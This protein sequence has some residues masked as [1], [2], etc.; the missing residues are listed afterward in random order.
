[1]P[2]PALLQS[3]LCHHAV[4]RLYCYLELLAVSGYSSEGPEELRVLN[5]VPRYR[6]S[7]PSSGKGRENAGSE[8]LLL[9]EGL[10]LC[11]MPVNSSLISLLTSMQRY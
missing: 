1:M 8:Q 2:L 11:L 10:I 9:G 4:H 5:G 6:Q 3:W 7:A